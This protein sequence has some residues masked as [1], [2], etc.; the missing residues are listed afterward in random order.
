M[1]NDFYPDINK[2]HADGW[3]V[4]TTL[5][6]NAVITQPGQPGNGYGNDHAYVKKYVI[7]SPADNGNLGAQQ[8][9]NLSTYILPSPS[10]SPIWAV[11]DH[12]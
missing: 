1:P 4:D 11:P 2:G 3:R 5:F 9:E 12:Q 8:D 10:S 7:G 6:N